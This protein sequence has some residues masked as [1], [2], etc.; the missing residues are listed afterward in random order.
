MQFGRED[1]GSGKNDPGAGIFHDSSLKANDSIF[2]RTVVI[3]TGGEVEFEVDGFHQVAVCGNGM[4]PKDVVVPPFPPNI[5]INDPDCVVKGAPG[6]SATVEFAQPGKYL[7][8]CNVTPHFV[9]GGMYGY[10]DVKK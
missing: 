6:A 10:V 3:P 2:P 5:F 4:R 9:D 1:I 8:I 7:I